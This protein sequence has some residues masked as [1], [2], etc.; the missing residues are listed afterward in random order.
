M[1]TPPW[2]DMTYPGLHSPCFQSGMYKSY[3]TCPKLWHQVYLPS[4]PAALPPSTESLL[5]LSPRNHPQEDLGIHDSARFWVYILSS[6]LPLF[7]DPNHIRKWYSFCSSVFSCCAT[8]LCHLGWRIWGHRKSC[9]CAGAHRLWHIV[10]GLAGGWVLLGSNP[11]CRTLRRRSRWSTNHTP[12]SRVPIVPQR[13]SAKPGLTQSWDT[14]R[15]DPAGTPAPGSPGSSVGAWTDRSPPWL[16]EGAFPSTERWPLARW[17]GA[18]R[19]LSASVGTF[20]TGE[21]GSGGCHPW[22]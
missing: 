7:P 1:A 17:L 10:G 9:T 4:R 11:H 16:S 15:T 20:G 18:G 2:K 3:L 8:V 13:H 22:K 21:G 19:C 12:W 6:H 5:H 14:G